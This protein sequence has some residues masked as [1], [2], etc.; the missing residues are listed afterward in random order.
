MN[1]MEKSGDAKDKI[2]MRDLSV[3]QT[4]SENDSQGLIETRNIEVLVSNEQTHI[5]DITSTQI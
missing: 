3:N 5:D 4:V 1:L 2:P